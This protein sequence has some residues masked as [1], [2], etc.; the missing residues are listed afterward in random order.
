MGL[1]VVMSSGFQPV[2]PEKYR[3]SL[4]RLD[5]VFRSI[6]ETVS[7]VS[8]HRCP[9]KNAQDRCTAQFGC[10]NQDRNVPHGQLYICTGSDDLDYRSAWNDFSGEDAAGAENAE[11]S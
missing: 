3:K 7:E 9:Y 10:R 11:I 5:Q 1:I 2:D 6:S 8:R 4:V